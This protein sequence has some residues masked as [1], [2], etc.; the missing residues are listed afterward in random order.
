MK[1]D[2]NISRE[3]C[4]GCHIG[5]MQPCRATYAQWHNGQFVVVPGM[6]AWRCDFC[7][8]TYYDNEALT[9][10]VLLLG[11]ET[12]S[13]HERRRRATGLDDSFGDGL[14]DR[15]RVC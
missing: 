9:R 15:W 4:E 6:P 5:T 11:P 1:T 8:D 14:G 10:L 3:F 12:G 13:E 7:G 2:D